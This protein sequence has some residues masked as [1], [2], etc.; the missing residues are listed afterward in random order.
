VRFEHDLGNGFERQFP[1]T[2]SFHADR[3]DPAELYLQLEDLWSNPRLLGPHAS[4]REAEFLV[5]RLLAV[6]PAYLDAILDRL[7]VSTEDRAS[8]VL[9]RTA[10]DVAV[11]GRLAA[12]F[13]EEHG[14]DDSPRLRLPGFALRRLVLRALRI[15][16]AARVRP[17]FIAAWTDGTAETEPP[18]DAVD[19][20]FFYALAGDDA[21]LRDRTLM[22]AAEGAFYQ[23]L[24]G[25]CLDVDNQAFE[26]EGSSFGDREEEI[27]RTIATADGMQVERGR[28]LTVFLRRPHHR[29]CKRLLRRLETFFLRRYDVPHAA[30][31]RQHA[32]TLARDER[33]NDRLLT[34]HSRRAYLLALF[35]PLTPFLGAIVGYERAPRLFDVLVSIDV[36][37]ITTGAF[38]FLA[39]RFLWRRDLSFFLA[40]VP[41]IGAG[42]IV[43]YLPVFLIDEVWDLAEQSLFPLSTVVFL[44]GTTTLLYLYLEVQR[45]LGERPE[46]FRRALDI[47]LLGLNQS[48]AF[49]LVVTT[50]LGPLMAVRNWGAAQATNVEQLRASLD[51]FLGELPRIIGVAPFLS[52]PTAILLMAF[53]AFFIGTFLQLLWEDLPMTEPL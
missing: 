14:L 30:A 48:A 49:G 6:L 7:E 12:R 11:F 19:V 5:T 50:L 47:F 17:E 31:M 44:L 27:L 36:A 3:H 16:V 28:D 35:V 9:I 20:S 13:I 38:W 45:Q 24:E 8:P 10:E 42:I 26:T 21:E 37:L 33:D 23:W 34:W 18:G 41:R 53:L 22:T 39:W 46:A 25:V 52:F 4:R 1:E 15:V 32:A 2:F 51:P 43:G 29:D 40:S